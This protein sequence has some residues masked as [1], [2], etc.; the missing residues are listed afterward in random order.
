MIHMK[1][2]F[3]MMILIVCFINSSE[4]NPGFTGQ[5]VDSN[6]Q[7]YLRARYYDPDT[8]AFLTKDTLGIQGG[9]NGFQY[10]ASDPINLLDSSG[11]WALVDD[12][13]FTAGGALLGLGS[14]LLSDMYKGHFTSG[15]GDAILAGA[16]GYWCR[17]SHLN[18]QQVGAGNEP[19]ILNG[20][21]RPRCFGRLGSVRLVTD[22]NGNVI[23][24]C[25]YDVFGGTR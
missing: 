25:N 7:V 2:C 4:A 17:G 13:S 20:E 3:V 10:C 8:G 18:I 21:M 24:S 6:G 19:H 15:Y 11:N 16:A 12:L 14:K 1:H 22:A 9:V 5:S 23:Q